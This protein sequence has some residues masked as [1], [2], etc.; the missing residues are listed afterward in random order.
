MAGRYHSWLTSVSRLYFCLRLPLQME[1]VQP[2]E[3]S[4]VIAWAL[5]QVLSLYPASRGC[6]RSRPRTT[7][8]AGKTNTTT[9]QSYTLLLLN[10]ASLRLVAYQGA[11]HCIH[12]ESTSQR[13][14]TQISHDLFN[15]S[16]VHM[17][18]QCTT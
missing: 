17:T 14:C 6:R 18:V 13:L 16:C 1:I 8:R 9:A 5:E 12:E 3:L 4:C 15:L 7:S 11:L 10:A 2:S